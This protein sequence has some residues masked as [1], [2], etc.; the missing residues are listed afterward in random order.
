LLDVRQIR[1]VLDAG[2]AVVAS[3]EFRCFTP[4]GELRHPVIRGWHRL[5]V[6][7]AFC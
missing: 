4:A 2:Q 6:S 5:K 7:G 1:A 3:I